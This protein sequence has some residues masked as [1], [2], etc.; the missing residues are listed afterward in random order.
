MTT[1]TEL[2]ADC[3]TYVKVGVSKEAKELARRCKDMLEADEHSAL[4]IEVLRAERNHARAQRDNTIR[5]LLSIHMLLYPAQVNMA[6]G[7]TMVFRPKNP[8]PHEVLQELSDR[9][10]AIPNDMMMADDKLRAA[11]TLAKD[12]LETIRRIEDLEY[13]SLVKS[14]KAIAALKRRRYE[15][16]HHLRPRHRCVSPHVQHQVRIWRS[17]F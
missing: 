6:D 4:T 7:N 3:S 11:A 2:I 17:Y 1:R 10:R 8:D 13:G 14:G 9:I 15:P 12:A 5:L 16:A